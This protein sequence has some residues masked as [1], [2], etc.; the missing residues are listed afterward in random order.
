MTLLEP[1]SARRIL[2]GWLLALAAIGFASRMAPLFDA[3]RRLWQWATED[4]YLM[5]TI[6]ENIAMGHGMAVAEG[7]I[8]TNGTQPLCTFVWAIAFLLSPDRYTAVSLVQGFEVLIAIASCILLYRLVRRWRGADEDAPALAAV[9]A[10]GWWASPVVVPHSMNCL[11]SGMYTLAVL[12]VLSVLGR[13]APGHEDGWSWPQS[14]QV[15]LALG[16]AFYARNDAVFL[17]AA[18]CLSHWIMGWRRTGVVW[19]RPLLESVVAGAVTVL[20]ALPWLRY[21]LTFGHI[22]PI[23]GISEAHGAAWG[24]NLHLLPAH[25]F[26]YATLYLPIPESL[27]TQ[28]LVVAATSA[29][30]LGLVIPIWFP[31]PWKP[32]LPPEERVGVLLF[33]FALCFYYGTL[34]GAPHFVGRYLYPLSP[35]LALMWA[36]ALL[37]LAGAPQAWRRWSFVAVCVSTVLISLG[38]AVRSHQR[39]LT[40]GH[41]QVVEFVQAH[42]EPDEWV[43]AIQSGTVGFFHPKT[44]NLDGKV[45]PEALEAKLAREVPAYV[46]AKTDIRFVVDWIG[47]LEW[48][49]RHAP[50][51]ENFDVRVEDPAHNLA[52]LERKAPASTRPSIDQR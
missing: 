40:N 9:T 2:N 28:S 39:G 7:T 14:L 42:A 13:R 10:M 33:G 36:R 8:A 23:S 22:T 17:I 38:T 20:L 21:N 31:S 3:E 48:H 32:A 15:G 47:L 12:C 37:G 30:L 24:S 35:F 41:R 18:V 49:E 43:G 4:G 27:E 19:G 6:A 26:E 5:M 52:V 34:F 51:R 44:Y 46:V 50:I 25:L 11:E 1:P 29:A 16:F 45:N